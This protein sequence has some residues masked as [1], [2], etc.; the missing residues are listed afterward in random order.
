MKEHDFIQ[1]YES[2]KASQKEAFDELFHYMMRVVRSGLKVKRRRL[3]VHGRYMNTF[4]KK[5]W[6]SFH[7]N[8]RKDSDSWAMSESLFEAV[9]F[10]FRRKYEKTDVSEKRTLLYEAHHLSQ[11]FLALEHQTDIFE[12]TNNQ[13]YRLNPTLFPA[14]SC[15]EEFTRFQLA[16]K[17]HYSN[18]RYASP[19]DEFFL[20]A[21]LRMQ[22]AQWEQS[23]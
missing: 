16:I 18:Y 22:Y 17:L 23:Q 10:Y 15:E 9:L 8:F 1:K 21:A 5:G 3:P 2:L 12:R 19:P 11:S 13:M 14:K 6:L 20:T 4:V 7:E